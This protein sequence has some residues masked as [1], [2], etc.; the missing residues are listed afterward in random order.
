MTFRVN[1][2]S[3]YRFKVQIFTTL[4]LRLSLQLYQESARVTQSFKRGIG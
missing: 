4:D 1:V 3:G 2:N